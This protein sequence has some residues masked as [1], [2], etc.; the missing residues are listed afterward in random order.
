ML[1]LI[2]V[3][4]NLLVLW[5][6]SSIFLKSKF[7][8]SL[9]NFEIHH[10]FIFIIRY[11]LLLANFLH[12]KVPF[13]VLLNL[14]PGTIHKFS[15]QQVGS[16]GLLVD[17]F[18]KVT[19][20]P[21]YCLKKGLFLAYAII[22]GFSI[23]TITFATDLTQLNGKD[24]NLNR[25]RVASHMKG[26]NYVVEVDSTGK[27]KKLIDSGANG[28]G[29][30]PKQLVEAM[31][32]SPL[33]SSMVEMPV[34]YQSQ[35]AI[36]F[37]GNNLQD[38]AQNAGLT[39]DKLK[40]MLL[41]DETMRIDQNGRILYVDNTAM[42]V[43]ETLANDVIKPS[44]VSGTSN[45]AT[46]VPIG[47]PAVLANTF[48][49]HS[50]KGASKT[51]YLD[52]NGHSAQGTA[53]SGSIITAPA[54]DLTGNP[55]VFDDTERSNIIK[56]WNRVSED[57]IPF[58]V[59][60]TTEA[61]SNDALL[62]TSATDT[63]Y[64]TRVVITKTVI[65]C[66]C[67]G[68]AYVGVVNLINN[69]SYQPAWVFQ[70]GLGNNEKNIAEAVSHEAGHTLGLLH[71]GQ[72]PSTGYYMGHGS[73]VTGW[74][75]IMGAGYYQ[76]VTQWNPGTYPNANNQQ[77]D[78][79]TLASVGILPSPDDYGNTIATASSMVNIGT[80]IAPTFQTYGIIET[81]N[82]IDMFVINSS[83]GL[84][85][86]TASPAAVG[87]NLDIKLTLLSATGTVI[88][89]SAPEATLTANLSQTVAAGTYYLAVA[90]SGHIASGTD[91]GYPSY[92]SLGQYQITGTYSPRTNTA[93][94]PIA[95]ISAT[96]ITGTAP[97]VVNF[98]AANSVG[99]GTITGYQWDFGDA[100]TA[101]G[102]SVSHT[103]TK[104]GTYTVKL[105]V[106]NQFKLTHSATQQIT[107]TAP[108]PALA[109][110]M[111]ESKVSMMVSV[112]KSVK[113]TVSIN[114]VDSIGKPVPNAKVEGAFS[115]SVTS[116][117]T[118]TTDANGSIVQSA[119]NASLSGRSVTYTLK[120]VTAT[121]YVYNP[122]KNAR[123]VVTL[124]W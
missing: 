58:D 12:R 99:N 84:V 80:S 112:S 54:Y 75:S 61:P 108:P 71:D 118:G 124:T 62:R 100:S 86:L 63:T 73:G 55:G 45:S 83:G 17:V 77:N 105:M 91:A 38:T 107:V 101:T 119:T 23:S 24:F 48:L 13:A 14:I 19:E 32:A 46:A 22:S 7:S 59:D 102:A 95:N 18:Y 74:A 30:N 87:P 78:I 76:N 52:F 37:L 41:Q 67:G 122:S 47:S 121:G 109:P 97:R 81:S 103:Y 44:N 34:T 28:D 16:V 110:T 117:V 114:L 11:D 20:M 96:P 36:N 106:T 33:H 3:V 85:N 82:D 79:A 35:D 56:I 70:D 111:W 53:W 27:I 94:A 66:G 93:V 120:N 4:K 49:L 104:V 60:I 69:T 2:S 26:R 65:N 29:T 115:G 113:A 72:K 51:I 10:S 6:I 90:N 57:Y 43:A 8:L 123:T 39:P 92:G 50:K 88:A 68:V 9:L 5:S 1:R 64:G 25:D 21:P 98:S 31:N 15:L 40:K 42:Q 89:T 116:T